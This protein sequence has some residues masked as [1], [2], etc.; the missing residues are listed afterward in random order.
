M[1]I[2]EI[3]NL[4]RRVDGLQQVLRIGA[5]SDP[6]CSYPAIGPIGS[7]RSRRNRRRRGKRSDILL[8]A[9]CLATSRIVA[10]ETG[11][12]AESPY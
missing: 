10:D 6:Q 8:R 1:V 9:L 3:C 11:G 4:L 12:S 5:H 7:G 2:D